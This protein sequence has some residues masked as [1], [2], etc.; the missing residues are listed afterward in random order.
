MS[1]EA[2]KI[3]RRS[4]ILA[5]KET[6]QFIVTNCLSWGKSLIGAIGTAQKLLPSQSHTLLYY[7]YDYVTIKENIVRYFTIKLYKIGFKNS[8]LY[9]K[10]SFGVGPCL[11]I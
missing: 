11:G 5:E 7:M 8:D 3:L 10:N 4:I 1:V 6:V 2:F 9:I